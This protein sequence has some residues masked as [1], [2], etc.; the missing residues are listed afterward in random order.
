MGFFKRLMEAQNDFD[1]DV[2]NNLKEQYRKMHLGTAASQLH[3]RL[4]QLGDTVFDSSQ[5]AK[6]ALF[7][8][9]LGQYSMAWLGNAKLRNGRS[10]KF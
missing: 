5:S 8:D 1:E 10:K 3:E 7:W 4:Y 2:I 9:P 6:R